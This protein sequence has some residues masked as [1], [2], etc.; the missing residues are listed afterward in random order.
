MNETRQISVS[1]A[2]TLLRQGNTLVFDAREPA[3]YR[4]GHI[5][6]ALLL[7]EMNVRLILRD[8]NKALPLMIY[9]DG[10]ETVQDTAKMFSEFGFSACLY[11]QCD[12]ET[13]LEEQR[14]EQVSA[15]LQQWL[16]EQGFEGDDLNQRGF[17]G[18]TPLMTAARHGHLGHVI[19]LIDWDVEINLQNNDGNTAVWL[20]C[21]S[22]NT[23]ILQVLIEAKANINTQNVNG[24]TPLIYA[25]SAG[26]DKM[27]DLLLQAGADT[28]LQTLDG[29]TALDAASTRPTLKRLRHYF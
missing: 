17:N 15:G 21:Y 5:P 20:A 28:Q 22:A 9:G 8:M 13:W 10:A 23:H 24:A 18:E 27:V 12:Y 6:N 2:N 1:E 19:E 29:F 25:A 4:C 14:M 7:W 3:A 16:G 11:L 26:R